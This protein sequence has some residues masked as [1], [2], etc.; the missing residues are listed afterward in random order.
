[1]VLRF[2][3]VLGVALLVAWCDAATCQ[4]KLEHTPPRSCISSDNNCTRWLRTNGLAP[5]RG[6]QHYLASGTGGNI[7]YALGAQACPAP[8]ATARLPCVSANFEGLSLRDECSLWVYAGC[9]DSISIREPDYPAVHCE[10]RPGSR[11]ALDSR[12]TLSPTDPRSPAEAWLAGEWIV[13]APSKRGFWVFKAD[14]TPHGFTITDEPLSYGRFNCLLTPEYPLEGRFGYPNSCASE[15]TATIGI[16]AGAGA[17]VVLIAALVFAWRRCRTRGKSSFSAAPASAGASSSASASSASASSASAASSAAASSSS[18]TACS[19][20]AS[21]SA[22]ASSAAASASPPPPSYSAA[23]A[24]SEVVQGYG[25]PMVESTEYG[26]PM[27]QGYG[28]P[29]VESTEYGLPMVQGYAQPVA[30]SG[31]ETVIVPGV[32]QQNLAEDLARLAALHRTGELTDTEYADAK[33]R[34]LHPSVCSY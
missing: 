5:G 9:G 2:A 30:A 16:A 23:A 28:L 11:V 12:S 34:V 29:M 8:S 15:S 33:A 4:N 10:M 6:Q 27:V 32:P 31:A 13:G 25:L 24:A 14:G 18:A 19:S 17:A 22:A 1:M 20:A 21:S 3:L 7:T 26:L